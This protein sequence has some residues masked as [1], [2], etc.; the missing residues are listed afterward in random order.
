M[1]LHNNIVF[2]RQVFSFFS[3]RLRIACVG[4]ER[5]GIRYLQGNVEDAGANIPGLE[6]FTEQ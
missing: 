2:M 5:D 1:F 6:S 4:W 3:V